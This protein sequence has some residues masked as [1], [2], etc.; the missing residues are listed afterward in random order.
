[1]LLKDSVFKSVNEIFWNEVFM[2]TNT[3]KNGQY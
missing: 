1:M 2:V 3:V